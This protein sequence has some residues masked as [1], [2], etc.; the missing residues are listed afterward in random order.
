MNGWPKSLV[1]AVEK[2]VVIPFAGSGVAMALRGPDGGPVVHNWRGLLDAA[3]DWLDEEQRREEADLLRQRLKADPTFAEAFRT[4]YRELGTEFLS[5]LQ[6]KLDP[7]REAVDD[8]SLGLARVLWRLSSNFV[9]T[10]GHDQALKWACP[11]PSALELIDA[12]QVPHTLRR[13]S[14]GLPGPALWHAF[15]TLEGGDP[16]ITFDAQR[17]LV[18]DP[19]ADARLSATADSLQELFGSPYP[20]LFVATSAPYFFST[21]LFRQAGGRRHYWLVHQDEFKPCQHSL[22][23]RD[24]PMIQPLSFPDFES[25]PRLLNELAE[26]RGPAVASPP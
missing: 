24:L 5:F 3:A 14:E 20:I 10:I 7:P 21:Q 11:N 15:G 13:L 4:V 19:T 25:L 16:I 1:R 2:G 26:R 18:P 22:R 17:S 6:D 12:T 9:V 23:E 8:A